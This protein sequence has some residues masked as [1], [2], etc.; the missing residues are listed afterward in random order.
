MANSIQHTLFFPHP[1]AIVWEYLTRANLMGLW[2]MKN[3][4]EPVVGHDFQFRTGPMPA[5]DFDGNIYCKVLEAE[6]CKKLTYSWKGGPGDGTFNLDSLVEWTLTEKDNGTEL[7]LVH[8]GFKDGN[9]AIVMAMNEG[10]KKNMHKIA[11]LIDA[12]KHDTTT[13]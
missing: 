8:S 4:F 2:L 9:S 1:S 3:D 6:P 13:V 12:G 10:W 11:E 7:S 5:F